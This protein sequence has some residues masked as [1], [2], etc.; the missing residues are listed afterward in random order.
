MDPDLFITTG[1]VLAGLGL[2]R[3]L[4]GA[5]P[6]AGR[7]AARAVEDATRPA[8]RVLRALPTPVGFV[9]AAA[10]SGVSLLAAT[11]VGLA[12]DGAD[13]VVAQVTRRPA[14]LATEPGVGDVGNDALVKAR[15][16]NAKAR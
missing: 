13:L 5:S 12:A 15:I 2:L 3:R 11:V 1:W 10:V 9:S 7:T 8:T 14:G 6:Q 4:R 16:P